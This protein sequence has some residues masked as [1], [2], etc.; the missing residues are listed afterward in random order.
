MSKIIV[1]TPNLP[2]TARQNRVIIDIS[3]PGPKGDKGDT[4]A[5]GTAQAAA[6]T[7]AGLGTPTAGE[8]RR[9][10]DNLGGL[11]FA[12][13]VSWLP[14]AGEMAN[15]KRRGVKGDGTTDDTTAIHAVKTAAG[16]GG[17]LVFPPGT[18]L[19]TG[20][21]ADV[22][23]QNWI[24][25]AGATLKLK[26][27][28]GQVPVVNITATDVQIDGPGTIDGNRAGQTS[29]TA[30]PTTRQGVAIQPAAHRAKVFGLTIKNTVSMGVWTDGAD[31][32][33]IERN[34][35]VDCGVANAN[36]KMIQA[37]FT[38][39]SSGLRICNNQIDCWT[40]N[41][42]G[43]AV[44][45]VGAGRTISRLRIQGNEVKVGNAGATATL[46]IELFCDNT[47]AIIKDASISGNVILGELNAITDQVYGISVGGPGSSSV[48]GATNVSVTGNV[49]RDCPA[50]SI[51]VIGSGISVSGNSCFNSGELL[52]AANQVTGGIR[53]V[54]IA[55]NTFYDCGV[56]N[57][58]VIAL[59]GSTNGI[60]G[61]T[62]TGN[63][64]YD[65]KAQGIRQ[66]GI[67]SGAIIQGNAVYGTNNAGM[68]FAGTF[69]DSAV[70]GNTMDLTGS[71]ANSDGIQ[72]ASATI[73]RLLIADNFIRGCARNGIYGNAASSGVD[74]RNN[75]IT[76][77][78]LHGINNA[79]AVDRWSVTGNR[80]TGND[81]GI[82]FFPAGTNI[83]V[84]GND[85]YSNPGGNYFLTGSTL[86]PFNIAG[87]D[88]SSGATDSGG[89][90]FEL[91]RTPNG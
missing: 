53:A 59:I 2:V 36:H 4:G 30:S 21:T 87:Q 31:D 41:N 81:R 40:Q 19:T 61:I 5:P 54:S 12:D 11:W 55:G 64:I 18:Y 45:C 22:A 78:T 75:T 91:L 20:L 3:T 43:I 35:I 70:V 50:F 48:S 47:T 6:S 57:L 72:L 39:D 58:A 66:T 42:G 29:I 62:V 86:V 84:Y 24:L 82:I 8:V 9:V 80:I 14:V 10:T 88:V 74:V 37:W 16:V 27:S 90:G 63:A 15:V 44:S 46:G 33:Q 73:T 34:R 71:A 32:V 28:S 51:E 23:S 77:C 1:S 13:G 83:N 60:Y 89:S 65:A 38:A 7:F 85:V 67:V 26:D 17:T 25:L 56:A 79:V 76:A 68:V 69:T 49:I 52:V